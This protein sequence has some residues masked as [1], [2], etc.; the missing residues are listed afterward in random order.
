MNGAARLA[1]GRLVIHALTKIPAEAM[2]TTLSRRGVRSDYIHWPSAIAAFLKSTAWIP[3]SAGDDFEGLTLGQCWLGSRSDI[4][5][6]VPRPERMV[7]ELIENNRYLQEMLSG[8]LNVPAWSDPKSAP[9]RIAALG[10]LLER[11]ISEAF[12]DDFRKAYREA[13][14]EYAQLDLRPALPSTLVIPK[15][16]IDGL[17]AVTLHKSAPLVETIYICLLYTSPSPRD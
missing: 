3:A 7:R 13:W 10:E 4:P 8:K 15:D 11:G 17:T 14:T 1:Y 9:R 5:R 6:F 16:T 2:V 12:L